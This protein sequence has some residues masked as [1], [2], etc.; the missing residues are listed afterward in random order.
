MKDE[1]KL[2]NT[3]EEPNNNNNN[4]FFYRDS[5]LSQIFVKIQHFRMLSTKI[6]STAEYGISDKIYL[7]KIQ[8][9]QNENSEEYNISDKIATFN[10]EATFIVINNIYFSQFANIEFAIVSEISTTTTDQNHFNIIKGLYTIDELIDEFNAKSLYLKLEKKNSKNSKYSAKITTKIT[11]QITLHLPTI[12]AYQLGL[13]SPYN[14]ETNKKRVVINEIPN[15]LDA[16]LIRP[17]INISIKSDTLYLKKTTVASIKLDSQEICDLF[18]DDKKILVKKSEPTYCAEHMPITN[19]N[20]Y[21]SYF[22]CTDLFDN[23]INF[24]YVKLTVHFIRFKI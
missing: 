20:I 21:T 11:T 12:I 7:N 19:N 18:E 15:E 22:T 8:F 24:K 3:R 17:F 2:Q 10:D 23:A 9:R 6:I 5:G 4:T 14:M 16:D 1:A 13:M